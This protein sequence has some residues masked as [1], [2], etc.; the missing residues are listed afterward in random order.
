MPKIQPK[1]ILF[2][3]NFLYTILAGGVFLKNLRNLSLATIL[4]L[5]LSILFSNLSF[6]EADALKLKAEAAVLM[7]AKSGQLLYE[8]NPNAKMYP[9]STTKIMTCILAI[10]NTSLSEPVTVDAQTPFEIEG[11]HIALEPGEV[12]TMEQ[13]LNA[14][15]LESA[16]D[17]AVVIA[18]HISGSVPA[19][20]EL[21]N[22]K[23]AELGALNTHFMNP[24]G[25]PDPNH[26]TTAHDLALIAK[27]CME[28][29]RFRGFVAKATDII[30]P[31]NIKPEQRFLN[32]SNKMLESDI[33]IDIDGVLVP[34]KYEGVTGIKTGYTDDARNCLVSG[35]IRNGTEYISVVLKSDNP[36]LYI[37][38]HKLLD[39]GFS[40]F[41]EDK[42][43]SKGSL[44]REIKLGENK[45][46]GILNGDIYCKH[47]IGKTPE[48]STKVTLKSDLKAPITK[49]EII[50]QIKYLSQNSVIATE[51][52]VS[53]SELTVVK[54]ASNK[55]LDYLL[56][57][58]SFSM[59]LILTR[60]IYVFKFRK[61]KS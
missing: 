26:Y 33:T 36:G 40:Q 9:A 39:Y 6:A 20:S 2:F 35:A 5:L 19:F 44:V 23:A 13:L 45:V 32:N 51:D 17:A 52:I 47:K 1:G 25:L 41:Q 8:K 43:A 28:N 53:G 42:I 30:P 37:D 38:S 31:T 49:G 56:L 59:I 46:S 3:S 14:L 34:I 12:L 29:P 57:A 16:N 61:Q 50:G 58:M 15:M 27:Y 24:N 60:I 4:S 18:K 22:K 48:L 10:E 54:P 55:F 7:D 21:M 11:S